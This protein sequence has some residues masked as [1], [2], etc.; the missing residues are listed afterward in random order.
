MKRLPG[1]G[2]DEQAP[3]ERA[4]LDRVDD[5]DVERLL[6][7][8]ALRDV[9]EQ[10]V[11]PLGGVVRGELLVRADELVEPADGRRAPRSGSP[12]GARS[13]SIPPSE[14]RTMPAASSSS[15]PGAVATPLAPF[16]ENESGSKPFRSVKR[17]ASSVVV[18][19][20]S[21]R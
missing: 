3:E 15:S 21:A 12:S 10:A 16:A 9:D 11:L 14:T 6:E 20:G 13:I 19:S 18:G 4:A 2:D 8:D 5:A 1:L 7:H 17:Q